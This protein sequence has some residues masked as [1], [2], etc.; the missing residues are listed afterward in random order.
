[1][2][3]EIGGFIGLLILIAD[4]WA[5]VNTISSTTSVGLKVFWVI[6]ILVLPF[7]GFLLWLVLGPRA[8]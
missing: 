2:R 3:I 5:I 6:L 7:I 8:A 1:M 4:V